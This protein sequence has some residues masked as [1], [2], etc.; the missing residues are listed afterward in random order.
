MR[1]TDGMGL[2]PKTIKGPCISGIDVRFNSWDICCADVIR[3]D[4]DRYVAR[5]V[6]YGKLKDEDEALFVM[7]QYKVV[8]AVGDTR[9][10]ASAMARLQKAAAKERIQFYRAQYATSPSTVEATL[11]TKER[12]VTL[13]R[14]MSL[15]NVYFA[16]STGLGIALPQN[17]KEIC[18]GAFLRE[19]TASNRVPVIWHGEQWSRWTEGGAADHAMHA[20]NYCLQAIRL[21]KLHLA[22]GMDIMA[23]RGEMASSLD[24]NLDDEDDRPIWGDEREDHSGGVVLEA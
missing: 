20:V 10:E 15:D 8:C 18:G 13:E 17:Y 2:P 21:G 9:P 5:I 1:I 22:R 12:L 7:R 24:D 23:S 16:T 3:P 19:M 6:F 4:F 11:N 14:T